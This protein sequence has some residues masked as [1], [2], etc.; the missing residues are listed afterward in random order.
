[1]LSNK[2][3]LLKE[4]F[5]VFAGQ[6][7]ATVISLI[8]LRIIT[9]L[10]SP[11]IFGEA[12]LW[13][14]IIILLK[15]IFISPVSNYQL[16]YYPKFKTEQNLFY[17][18]YIIYKYYRNSFLI[19]SLIFVIIIYVL[20]ISNII[21]IPLFFVPGLIIYYISDIMKSNYLN[22]LSAERKQFLFALWTIGDIIL[23]YSFAL[24]ALLIEKSAGYYI[25]GQAFGI[26][27]G[28][29]IFIPFI[30]KKLIGEERKIIKYEG[31]IFSEFKKYGLPFIPMAIIIWILS[32]G[33]RYIL[34]SY[35]SLI[36]VGIFTAA[37]SISSRPF[38]F[39]SGVIGNFFRPILFQ[40]ESENNKT[41]TNKV[42]KIWLVIT[43]VLSVLVFLVFFLVGDAIAGIL[44]AEEYHSNISK[45]FITIGL[46]Y[47]F[48]SIFQ[49]IENIMFSYEKS[50]LVLYCHIT[51]VV[52]F[53]V[54][55]IILIEQ[56]GIIGAGF[57]VGIVYLIQLLSGIFFLK[58][59]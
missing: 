19:S 13:I 17:F 59:V 46:G 26:S 47:L 45:L 27:L 54:A 21:N 2:T 4:G 51:A 35:N 20:S 31:D 38:L 6:A 52:T 32:L 34:N 8:A 56:F 25:T 58:V 16:R 23:M 5:W 43:S 3:Y 42:I 55:N 48:F 37:F 15:N 57:A 12:T 1:L 53:F 7:L 44:L 40:A 24:I 10:I 41:K 36:E 14:G 29:I 11:D 9:E 22:K 18:N 50:R 33:N 49:V 30:K 28:V 39:F